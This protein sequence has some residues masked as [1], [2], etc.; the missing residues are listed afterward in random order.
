MR[1]VTLTLTSRLLLWFPGQMTRE[2]CEFMIQQGH[3]ASD[4]VLA[5]F[6]SQGL[7]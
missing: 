4:L 6:H 7:I 5:F 2:A 3:G 1:N